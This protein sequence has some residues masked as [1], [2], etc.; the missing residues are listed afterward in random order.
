MTINHR[1]EAERHLSKASFMTGDGPHDFP[2]N[3]A[4]SDFHLRAAQVHATLAAGETQAADVASY[5]AA[6]AAYRYALIRHVAEG[7]GLSETDEAHQHAKGLARHLDDV[8]LNV[9]DEVEYHL[10]EYVGMDHKTALKSPSARKAEWDDTPP[11]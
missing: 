11:F 4:L 6:I 1:A 7:L 3:P 2:V 9:D 5:R 8:G 10:T